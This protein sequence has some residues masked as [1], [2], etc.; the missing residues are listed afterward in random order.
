MA[1][2]KTGR[3]KGGKCCLTC[4]IVC[5]IL[6]VLFAVALVVGAN[7][8]F[9]KFVS[10]HIGGV[11]LSE[12]WPLITGIFK[13]DEDK[14]VTQPYSSD[15][16]YGEKGFYSNLNNALLQKTYTAEENRDL[17]ITEKG[18]ESWNALSLEDQ[19]ALNKEDYVKEKGEESWNALSEE[20]KGKVK[21]YR[22][23]AQTLLSVVDLEGVVGEGTVEEAAFAGEVEEEGGEDM[24]QNLAK[25]LV[26]DFATITKYYPYDDEDV[27][28]DG[29]TAEE[30][31]IYNRSITSFTIS[32]QQVSALI[33][34]IMEQLLGVGGIFNSSLAETPLDGVDL[35]KLL[36]IP[37]VLVENDGEK[38]DS[39][40]DE[41]LNVDTRLGLTLK[42]NL[43]T[44][45]SEIVG[46]MFQQYNVPDIAM[47]AVNTILPK[48]LFLTA[49]IYPFGEGKE[50]T[51][52]INNYD[53]KQQKTLATILN[54]LLGETF[55]SMMEGE[56]S[57]E[58]EEGATEAA[59]T[60][61]LSINDMA[62]K[63]FDGVRKLVPMNFVADGSRIALK[64][65]HIQAL[66]NVAGLYDIEDPTAE[67]NITP[68]MFL[69]A[70][71]GI[72]NGYSEEDA[73]YIA[74]L[75][76]NHKGVYCRK[77]LK[78]GRETLME[79]QISEGVYRC[80][81]CSDQNAGYSTTDFFLLDLES[82]YAMDEGAMAGKP[83]DLNEDSLGSITDSIN[84][85]NLIYLTDS[86]TDT[87][88]KEE[89]ANEKLRVKLGDRS[90]AH[91]LT[92]TLLNMEVAGA[93]EEE[94]ESNPIMDAISVNRIKILAKSGK[95]VTNFSYTVT[96]GEGEDAHEVT[97]TQPYAHI[98]DTIF[99]VVAELNIKKLLNEMTA[100]EEGA[101]PNPLITSLTDAMPSLF[102]L[103]LQITVR[104]G[105]VRT[106]TMPA[107]VYT[108]EVF[109]R[110]FGNAEDG[111]QNGVLVN[112]FDINRTQKLMSTL[113]LLISKFADEESASAL[114]VDQL[115]TTI[116]DTFSQ[117]F[118]TLE[119][120]LG[121]DLYFKGG[122]DGDN[123]AIIL[124]NVYEVVS[125][126]VYRAEKEKAED[127]ELV[128]RLSAKEVS[129][130]F[131]GIYNNGIAVY[132][133]L[134]V[135]DGDYV[136]IDGKYY[137]FDEGNPSHQGISRY[138][139]SARKI[140]LSQNGDKVCIDGEYIDYD[141]SNPAHQGL[142]R[143][144]ITYAE[145]PEILDT[146]DSK[147]I[148]KAR[149][150]DGDNF[151]ADLSSKYYLKTPLTA[152]KLFGDEP[153]DSLFGADSL[154]F[155]EENGLY[156][157]KRDI[158]DLAVSLSGPALAG[159]LN[160]SGVLEGEGLAEAGEES[161]SLMGGL[162]ILTADFHSQDGFMY[163]DIELRAKL[164]ASS[165]GSEGG[166]NPAKFIP[167]Y[168]Y[169][170]AKVMVDSLDPNFANQKGVYQID[171]EGAFV[172]MGGE[173]IAYDKDD[174]SHGELTRY[175][176]RPRYE[177]TVVVN[178][179]SETANKN[180]FSVISALAGDSFD[181]QSIC[182]T[183]KDSLESAFSQI[184]DYIPVSYYYD[185]IANGDSM[186]L[187]DLFDS[188][189]SISFKQD[190]DKALEE[191]RSQLAGLSDPLEI[192]AKEAEIKAKESEKYAS[193]P[194]ENKELRANLQE[195]GRN[196]ISALKDGDNN[197]LESLTNKFEE[198]DS[199]KT[200][201]DINRK[202]YINGGENGEDYITSE[203]LLGGDLL[204]ADGLTADTLFFD[205]TQE[206]V[207]AV[208]GTTQTLY[209]IY[210]DTD[211]FS[212]EDYRVK[213]SDKALAEILYSNSDSDEDDS[214]GK[215]HK[216]SLGD[217][218]FGTIS[219]IIIEEKLVESVLKNYMTLTIETNLS[220]EDEAMSC[221][222]P[223]RIFIT[224][225]VDMEKT[226][227]LVDDPEN[228][229]E[230]KSTLTAED[231]Q[232]GINDMDDEETED[233]FARIKK[234]SSSLG[235]DAS[236]L[237][238]EEI[239][240]TVADLIGDN[241]KILAELPEITYGEEG[242]EGYL[243]L[244][245]I[246]TLMIEECHVKDHLLN[247]DGTSQTELVGSIITAIKVDTTPEVLCERLRAFG[248]IANE[249]F[250]YSDK[251][252]VIGINLEGVS[253][254]SLTGSESFDGRY[255]Y[256]YLG[257]EED[258]FLEN[259]SR[260]MYLSKVF[261]A[262]DLLGEGDL[263]FTDND[264]NFKN[265]Y[266]YS[267]G[268]MVEYT[269]NL[270]ERFGADYYYANGEGDY[271]FN[272]S[273]MVKYTEGA[274]GTRYTKRN[275]YY[276][277]YRDER[278][279]EE[280][281]TTLDNKSLGALSNK[282]IDG[283]SILVG[284]CCEN[285]TKGA[286][287]ECTNCFGKYK[288]V[289]S[290]RVAQIL[291][292]R[293]LDD[294]Y[295]RGVFVFKASEDAN[296]AIPENLIL[297]TRTQIQENNTDLTDYTT[298]IVINGMTKEE[299]IQLF[300]N[301]ISLQETGSTEVLTLDSIKDT[302]SEKLHEIFFGMLDKVKGASYGAEGISLPNLFEYLAS[303]DGA[304]YYEHED[305]DYVYLD[306]NYIK[307][308]GSYSAY[309]HY[310]KTTGIAEGNWYYEKADGDY[311][312]SEKYVEKED[313]DY[314]FIEGAYTPYDALNPNH[315]DAVRYT[316][317]L[318]FIPYEGGAVTRYTI[319]T[320]PDKL[321]AVQKASGF[322]ILDSTLAE[323][324]RNRFKEF[325]ANPAISFDLDGNMVG[326]DIE[327]AQNFESQEVNKF[328]DVYTF[329]H[330]EADGD[331]F[332]HDFSRNLYF[333]R[334]LTVDELFEGISID[335][336]LI[337]FRDA[338]VC[339]D[340]VMTKL[341]ATFLTG[342]YDLDC[343]FEYDAEGSYTFDGV[344]MVPYVGGE[345]L[346]YSMLNEPR[347][348]FYGA[349][350]D[351]RDSIVTTLDNRALASLASN[352]QW[353]GASEKGVIDVGEDGSATIIQLL[354]RKLAD[355]SEYITGVFKFSPKE[356]NF[357]MPDELIIISNTLLQ[358]PDGSK[359][360]DAPTQVVINGMTIGET[361]AFFNNLT[362]IQKSLGVDGTHLT[363]TTLEE[364]L[365]SEIAKVMGDVTETIEGT[366]Y[367]DGG[368]KLPNMF[369]YFTLTADEYIR[370][371]SATEKFY[372]KI[373]LDYFAYDSED[374]EHQ[375]ALASDGKYL[376]GMY[377]KVYD[378]MGNDTGAYKLTTPEDFQRRLREYGKSEGIL[379]VDGI[380]TWDCNILENN[381][382]GAIHAE[383]GE[384]Y[385]DNR[386]ESTSDDYFYQSLVDYYYMTE[387]PTADSLMGSGNMFADI[388][389]SSFNMNGIVNGYLDGVQPY[390]FLQ[391]DSGSYYCY[392]Q[393][394]DYFNT[395]PNGG[396]RYI[397]LADGLSVGGAA[398]FGL[399]Y[400]D[401]A[402]QGG[403]LSDKA[404]ASIITK[405]A[406][407]SLNV[408][409][410]SGIL[411]NTE[412]MGMKVRAGVL[413]A[414]FVIETT[415]KATFNKVN[416]NIA[417]NLSALPDHFYL[418][419]FT[420]GSWVDVE[421]K[422][423]CETKLT[424]NG[425]GSLSG[426]TENLITNLSQMHVGNFYFTS[427]FN[428]DDVKASV[429]NTIQDSLS[430]LRTALNMD[431]T[432]NNFSAGEEE[433]GKGFIGFGS[434]YEVLATKMGQGEDKAETLQDIL[435]KLHAEI[436]SVNPIST[437][438]NFVTD[439]NDDGKKLADKDFGRYLASLYD[440]TEKKV[441]ASITDV[442]IVAQNEERA[443]KLA[444]LNAFEETA[445]L[446]GLSDIVFV[447]AEV[448]MSAYAC[449]GAVDGI[450]P[451][452]VK[453]T[454]ALDLSHLDGEGGAYLTFNGM[455][456]E[457]KALLMDILTTEGNSIDGVLT[458]IKK[459]TKDAFTVIGGGSAVH[460]S[461][462]EG[463]TYPDSTA[464]EG[465]GYLYV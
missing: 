229:G 313:G 35:S 178:K 336:N 264:F 165:L 9:N 5:I 22:I 4:L 417:D 101:E 246:Y 153:L 412:I 129:D 441:E 42:L 11:K 210:K 45:V 46:P 83:F 377:E 98:E 106:S 197:G 108:K 55:A 241:M 379:K 177:T 70:L 224:V 428:L 371:D 322:Y 141:A 171:T 332:L 317:K 206:Y 429:N 345:T 119:D 405:T 311:V 299:T 160:A 226:M 191:L 257:G 117:V 443:D 185:N 456:A 243:G 133:V 407:D 240:K 353:E 254:F 52:S 440:G 232:L 352:H 155:K 369:E 277:V 66:L 157:D 401:G 179:M 115:L 341:D 372:V 235:A 321:T 34:D 392:D 124:P 294:V 444:Y 135:N 295:V 349:F 65:D 198:G 161:N 285:P 123:G 48:K 461:T 329:W 16:L 231:V 67:S 325:G 169:V 107:G 109:Y 112:K 13:A 128:K 3:S 430:D 181:T 300:H 36:E 342:V 464:I 196:P 296:V 374:I 204:S 64:M 139:I 214:N 58:A 230:K 163:L 134:P 248:R 238:A 68:H 366:E 142:T 192:E 18:E 419:T 26:F 363:I 338:Y 201:D 154:N 59:N 94:S 63:M 432:F 202:Y 376:K 326:I 323:Q 96:E 289:G 281:S 188:L 82:K 53:K 292:E 164:D 24:I 217:M 15:D 446:A 327:N 247:P 122:E 216:M 340:E 208:D 176:F 273:A 93:E 39:L 54:A 365:S 190:K 7:F 239:K 290:A 253:D 150:E 193:D 384:V 223:E 451:H 255:K 347:E 360:V 212:V 393:V 445:T 442:Y 149:E 78:E 361:R 394:N 282:F 245:D 308:N 140:T 400:Y 87:I 32:G 373:G 2:Q 71:N 6:A 460:A 37:Q 309:I 383:S 357:V 130:V 25:Q 159:I 261:T 275:L 271:V 404:M 427:W 199:N 318:A 69:S 166:F 462:T 49:C 195:F 175:A 284:G 330:T 10:P 279:W 268:T 276:G 200:V 118:T 228:P 184:T 408:S 358:N 23:N 84:L 344:D 170:T 147:V 447:T 126:L 314:V 454:I 219:Q 137:L 19:N 250:T 260:N 33:A 44:A 8:A 125:G 244:P 362:D 209:G 88:E 242:G 41:Q 222:V 95:D 288:C 316:K 455:T 97:K 252:T 385:L 79:N 75:S 418:T 1:R 173:Y 293:D 145:V 103:Q 114:D 278:P 81:Y 301:L 144:N 375:T 333:N 298:D 343:N 113:K 270:S 269:P 312:K 205:G 61:M 220:L 378:S 90:L 266:D 413:G 402:Q 14:I 148:I 189:N 27:D 172:S 194:V 138:D 203:T 86:E 435:T 221:L 105:F 436:P 225:V 304:Y 411:F 297:I 127:I 421:N 182:D 258:L 420:S 186:V 337:N 102:V 450:L 263:S 62:R 104:E 438:Y 215:D 334:F 307:D 423:V 463:A 403:V 459:V 73:D 31:K 354:L 406:G 410:A 280:V 57:A 386:Y 89:L 146:A 370:D 272:G 120:T 315:E 335:K 431:L 77:C 465:I 324:I 207:S 382:D 409:N 132:D 425:F 234:L 251:D 306:G 305:G 415:V 152:E 398:L 380:H 56:E 399:N 218:G 356:A 448:D 388:N 116:S 381:G 291:I 74:N 458:D 249:D 100:G 213:V 424:L 426:E 265:I 40:T 85:A 433:K 319:A 47:K 143:Y 21:Y 439:F 359:A 211:T 99:D 51:L 391:N 60:L 339:V 355:G 92:D 348:I 158:E 43:D 259:F 80:G 328:E 28:G 367:R 395:T 416:E 180:L 168:L 50:A 237:D 29:V 72:A 12:A 76:N 30:K 389:A 397:K 38:V 183:V 167:E 236:Q 91:L 302:V 136:Y 17:Y 187:S 437:D 387:K 233:F 310:E 414:E 131:A 303:D 364:K 396:K 457:E 274:S 287:L 121:S 283:G 351:T 453:A 390:A 111:N 368:I 174:P 227:T 110:D 434:F 267:S 422:Y 262:E 151:L 156:T 162:E 331:R 286:G 350:I 20:E 320:N 346:R 449:S 256:F 452:T